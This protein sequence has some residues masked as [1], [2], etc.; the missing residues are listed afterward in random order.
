MSVRLLDFGDLAFKKNSNQ[1]IHIGSPEYGMVSSNFFV[2]LLPSAKIRE[3]YRDRL[4]ITIEILN[5]VSI[6]KA[7]STI[8]HKR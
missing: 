1:N 2:Y 5:I 7:P 3:A 8:R 4:N 6:L